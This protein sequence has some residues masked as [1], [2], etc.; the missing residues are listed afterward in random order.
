MQ[1]L[2]VL[3][4]FHQSNKIPHTHF[5]FTHISNSTPRSSQSTF[6]AQI[7]LVLQL[8]CGQNHGVSR[9]LFSMLSSR[10]AAQHSAYCLATFLYILP[11][12]AFQMIDRIKIG[13][14]THRAVIS[15]CPPLWRTRFPFFWAEGS[16]LYQD[17]SC[18][19]FIFNFLGC[20][21]NKQQFS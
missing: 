13:V 4:H 6:C 1:P 7:C 2:P 12:S 10:F 16:R 17:R 15:T 20:C 11:P 5:Q 8:L 14:I 18:S 9:L 21:T 19:T 3:E